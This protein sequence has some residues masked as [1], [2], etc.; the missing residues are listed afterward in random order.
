MEKVDYSKQLYLYDDRSKYDY[1]LK[2]TEIIFENEDTLL[3]KT[4]CWGSPE[5]DNQEEDQTIMIDKINGQVSNS[6]F[7]SWLVTSDENW[8]KE[9]VEEMI[10][11]Y[12]E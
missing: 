1:V 7:Y 12:N 3:C 4:V 6:D 2:V 5:Y 11:R 10:E 9:E 8:I